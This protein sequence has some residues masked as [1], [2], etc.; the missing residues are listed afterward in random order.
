MAGITPFHKPLEQEFINTYVQLPFQEI[1]AIAQPYQQKSDET[2]AKAAMLPDLFKDVKY[3]Q[4]DSPVYTQAVQKLSDAVNSFSDKYIYNTA[5][6]EAQKAYRELTRQVVNNKTMKDLQAEYD[7]VTNR[8]TE[9]E[10]AKASKEG[11]QPWQQEMFSQEIK[12]RPVIRRQLEDGTYDLEDVTGVGASGLSFMT[13]AEARPVLNEYVDDIKASGYYNEDYTADE[14]WI[15]GYGA[16]GVEAAKIA[17]ILGI[18]LGLDK[19]NKIEV[20]NINIPNDFLSTTAGQNM[21]GQA[22]FIA[23]NSNGKIT[24]K[25]ALDQLYLEQGMSLMEEYSYKVT[26][27][28]VDKGMTNA[29][30]YGGGDL[31]NPYGSITSGTTPM[32]LLNNIPYEGGT[33][34][35]KITEYK[36]GIKGIESYLQKNPTLK[37]TNPLVYNKKQ[38]SLDFYRENLNR[39]TTARQNATNKYLGTEKGKTAIREY[40]NAVNTYNE[41]LN[42]FETAYYNSVLKSTGSKTQAAKEA[43]EARN[44]IVKEGGGEELLRR[45]LNTANIVPNERAA[46]ETAVLDAKKVYKDKKQNLNT[47]LTPYLKEAKGIIPT[48]THDVKIA[49]GEDM[50]DEFKNAYSTSWVVLSPDQTGNTPVGIN[51]KM[52]EPK[53]IVNIQGTPYLE[54]LGED[55]NLYY[56]TDPST[57]YNNPFIVYGTNLAAAARKQLAK[58]GTDKVISRDLEKQAGY[59]WV[60]TNTP[61]DVTLQGSTLSAKDLYKTVSNLYTGESKSFDNGLSVKRLTT[62]EGEEEYHIIYNGEA[63]LFNDAVAASSMLAMLSA[64]NNQQ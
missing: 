15:K 37:T 33:L 47:G 28:I 42:K 6:Q 59:G 27:S 49:N 52:K 18:N 38:A 7:Y 53:Q 21:K 5:S 9:F 30:N 41:S 61:T 25:E 8:M 2:A 11:I 19:N 10:K 50:S 36:E 35:D 45:F 13:G 4:K 22:E 26:K 60:Y 51:P 62:N 23:E 29:D 14:R 39:A 3:L 63:K 31:T 58:K 54:F 48:A 20:K 12:S 57:A 55:G 24:T 64:A 1:A 44:N 32:G 40:N 16:E 43:R 17:S 56:G 46:I 34:D